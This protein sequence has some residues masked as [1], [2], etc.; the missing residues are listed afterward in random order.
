M[1]RRLAG[2]PL[3]P[4]C[5][6]GGISDGRIVTSKLGF[7]IGR[8]NARIDRWLI[9]VFADAPLT[10]NPL[11]IVQDA[12]ELNDEQMRRI[13]GESN[14]AETTFILQ[15]RSEIA[16]GSLQAARKC[17][18]PGIIPSG[19]GSGSGNMGARMPCQSPKVHFHRPA[20]SSHARSMPSRNV[21][22]PTADC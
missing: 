12:D 20:H 15:R 4:L 2:G 7:P 6:S 13:A 19:H 1:Y 11:G 3:K 21:I 8:P 9:D 16:V 17:S 14:Q 10:G 22:P 18:E 5:L